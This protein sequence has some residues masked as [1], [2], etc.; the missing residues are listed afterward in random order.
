MVTT[1]VV[2]W[3]LYHHL[4]Q[5]FLRKLDF[6]VSLILYNSQFTIYQKYW[7]IH[8]LGLEGTSASI[9][10][11]KLNLQMAAYV[12]G[13]KLESEETGVHSWIRQV[14]RAHDL[15]RV[16]LF[17]CTTHPTEECVERSLPTK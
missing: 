12:L 2:L 5:K 1:S 13:G 10:I 9:K 11:D 16:A 17:S 14:F 4:A 3:L 8:E 6:D 7:L 15:A